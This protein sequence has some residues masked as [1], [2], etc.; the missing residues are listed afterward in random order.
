M[1]KLIDPIHTLLI[2]SKLKDRNNEQQEPEPAPPN[3]I[4]TVG[5]LRRM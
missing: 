4:K 2:L 5:F 1:L 3:P